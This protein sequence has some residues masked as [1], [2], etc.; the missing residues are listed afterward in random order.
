[1]SKMRVWRR[2]NRHTAP[3]QRPQRDAS[4][5]SSELLNN[6]VRALRFR[7]IKYLSKISQLVRSELG[8]EPGLLSSSPMLSTI[9]IS[10]FL[11]LK[12]LLNSYVA[13]LDPFWLETTAFVLTEWI[14]I[15][16]NKRDS[17]AHLSSS[18]ILLTSHPIHRYPEG[19]EM[20]KPRENGEI[21][22][23]PFFFFLV[24]KIAMII[25][26]IAQI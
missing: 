13:P 5:P 24:Y 17:S 19:S 26:P 7:K 15:S 25:L 18:L 14:F 2:G 22:E 8:F 10:G 11:Q 6:L 16:Y 4:V 23:R 1:M 21:G 9:S 20:E 12:L 3:A